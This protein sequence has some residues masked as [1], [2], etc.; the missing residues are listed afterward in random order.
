LTEYA[1]SKHSTQIV[2]PET[3][4]GPIASAP[5]T[6]NHKENVEKRKAKVKVEA[7]ENHQRLK[8]EN[9]PIRP[10]FNNIRNNLMLVWNP[11]TFV[12]VALK[13]FKV[14]HRIQLIF[15]TSHLP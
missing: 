8:I 1:G 14:L 5:P 6:G 4:G 9:S 13:F 11:S 3:H 7:N 12:R 2:A 10:S 15:G